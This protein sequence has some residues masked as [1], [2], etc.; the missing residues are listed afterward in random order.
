MEAKRISIDNAMVQNTPFISYITSL[1]QSYTSH[2][3]RRIFLCTQIAPNGYWFKTGHPLVGPRIAREYALFDN[4]KALIRKSARLGLGCNRNGK[5]SQCTKREKRGLPK[6]YGRKS[7]RK[8]PPTRRL[9]RT[10]TT[11][12]S[13]AK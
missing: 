9:E 13:R 8:F 7:N 4:K 5:K 1:H 2:T 12:T 11:S 6:L 10:S 3:Y